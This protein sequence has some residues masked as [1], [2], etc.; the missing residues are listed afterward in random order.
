LGIARHL[1]DNLRGV[2]L[3]KDVDER[4]GDRLKDE[5]RDAST[6]SADGP[7]AVRLPVQAC[8]EP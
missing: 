4:L 7:A 3:H 6:L 5:Q 1:S 8:R 2:R